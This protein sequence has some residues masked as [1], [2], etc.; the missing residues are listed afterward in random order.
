MLNSE[1]IG[2]QDSMEPSDGDGSGESCAPC[3]DCSAV[4]RVVAN[5]RWHWLLPAILL[6]DSTDAQEMGASRPPLHLSYHQDRRI[7]A[8]TI[9]P[10]SLDF[11]KEWREMLLSKGPYIQISDWMQTH[12]QDGCRLSTSRLSSLPK[13]PTPSL[14]N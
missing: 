8:A 10:V 11:I 13:K 2:Q 6:G 9:K 14:T 12:G 5:W 7:W 3:P 4:R 1:V